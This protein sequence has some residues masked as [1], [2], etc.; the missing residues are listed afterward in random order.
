MT[1]RLTN[2]QRK[3]LVHLTRDWVKLKGIPTNKKSHIDF[4]NTV[5]N[6][7]RQNAP[8]LFTYIKASMDLPKDWTQQSIVNMVRRAVGK[9][10]TVDG[11]S[12]ELM[13][14]FNY[15]SPK[16]DKPKSIPQFN[17]TNIT[18]ANII[19]VPNTVAVIQKALNNA[20]FSPT[21][22][23][24]KKYTVFEFLERIGVRVV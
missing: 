24:T 17:A 23:L 12:P 8:E 1:T 6:G 10:S 7:K 15:W 21:E 16:A 3:Q 4:L 19:G 2:E 14:Y 22:L 9:G 5:I 18:A 11:T 20:T 13:D